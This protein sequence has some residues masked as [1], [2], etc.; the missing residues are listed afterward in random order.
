MKTLIPRVIVGISLIGTG[1]A[2]G[3]HFFKS[4]DGNISLRYGPFQFELQKDG[5]Q[6]YIMS[7]GVLATSLAEGLRVSAERG[8]AYFANSGKLT[9]F[10]SLDAEGG[11]VMLKQSHTAKQPRS[12][13]IR[14]SKGR[15]EAGIEDSTVRLSGPVHIFDRDEATKRVL[16]ISGSSGVATLAS[17]PKGKVSPLRSAHLS[18]PIVLDIAQAPTKSGEKPGQV[19][20][21]GDALTLENSGA[22]PL[23]RMTGHVLI[24]GKQGAFNGDMGTFQN[25]LF[26][27]NSLRQISN[28]EAGGGK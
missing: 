19:H 12:T 24:H 11:V 20:A 9:A 18:G 16:T 7:G 13:E 8:T 21:T 26:R 22:S 17:R 25:V 5:T 28:I 4:A 1:L 15:Y 14:C 2:Q 10:K 27:L 6:R 23:I 3:S